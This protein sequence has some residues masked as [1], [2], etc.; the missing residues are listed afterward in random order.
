MRPRKDAEY[1]EW[2]KRVQHY[3]ELGLPLQ[4]ST[5]QKHRTDAFDM[6][7]E[8]LLSQ[9]WKRQAQANRVRGMHIEPLEAWAQGRS[10]NARRRGSTPFP[11]TVGLRV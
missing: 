1:F 2:A 3:L 7:V 9:E 10:A 5:S 8:E 4:S 6:V 11:R